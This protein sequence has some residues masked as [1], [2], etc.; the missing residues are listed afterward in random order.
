MK[1]NMKRDS[2]KNKKDLK[3]CEAERRVRGNNSGGTELER[4]RRRAKRKQSN[5]M[6]FNYLP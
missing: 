1:R 6:G 2:S 5:V 3:Q 4:L